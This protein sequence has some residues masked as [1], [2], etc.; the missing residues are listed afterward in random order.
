VPVR[1][2]SW[3][4]HHHQLTTGKSCQYGRI[5]GISPDSGQIWRAGSIITPDG[6]LV[7]ERGR[8]MEQG[9]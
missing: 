4:F 3:D 6:M 9:Q 5:P 2:N 1:Q 8:D 7:T